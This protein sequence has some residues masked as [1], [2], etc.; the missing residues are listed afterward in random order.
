MAKEDKKDKAPKVEVEIIR[1]RMP[2]AIAAAIKLGE[3]SEAKDSELAAKYRTTNGK[4]ADIRADRNFA[5]ITEGFKPTKDMVDAAKVYAEQCD[6]TN[7]IM[8]AVKSFGV[9]TDEEAEAF[10]TAR[11]GARKP[12]GK[13]KP[14]KKSSKKA[15][16]VETA[17]EEL[18][19][20]DLDDLLDDD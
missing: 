20:D 11:K 18:E 13:A 7:S 12:T 5:Y 9:A 1:G 10:V 2:V 14:G 16:E 8:K 3:N 17:D 15:E 6:S 4:I 19:E